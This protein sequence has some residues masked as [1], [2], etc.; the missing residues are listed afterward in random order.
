MTRASLRHTVHFAIGLAIVA[1]ISHTWYLMGL[2]TP[3]VVSGSSMTPTL[4]PG[5]QLLVDRTAFVLRSPRRWEVVVLRCPDRAD[6]FCVK[7]IVALPGET[8][9]LI[10]GEVFVDG[11]RVLKAASPAFGQSVG[12]ASRLPINQAL[13]GQTPA[14]PTWQLGPD[15]YFVVGDNSA[16]SDDSRT[17]VSPGGLDARLLVG[18]PLGVR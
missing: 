15:E 2:V 9:W 12:Q 7:R 3:V 5:D 14:L 16:A 8:V 10:G 18:R 4:H 17:W 11:R 1:I 6:E 13:A